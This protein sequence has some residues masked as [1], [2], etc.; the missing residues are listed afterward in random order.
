MPSTQF[1]T[2]TTTGAL[3]CT[4]LNSG[5]V[6]DNW[7]IV[8]IGAGTFTSVTA[9]FQTTENGT[10]YVNVA[11]IRLDTWGV[12]Q[13]PT[14]TN[15]T[16]RHWRV[17][18]GGA[19]GFRVNVTAVTST[20]GMT[21]NVNTIYD[22]AFTVQLANALS[23]SQT[24]SGAFTSSGGAVSLN[25]SS[26]F[27]TAINTGT[28]TGTVGIGN[29]S[30]GALTVASGAASTLQVTG[31]GLTVGT[32]TSGTTAVVS[33]G[34]LTLTGVGAS[35]WTPGAGA[36]IVSDASTGIKIA[37]AT[38]QKLGFFNATAVVQPAANTDT[39][40]GAAGGTTSVYLNTTFN[41]AGTA[42]YTIGGVVA[43]LKALGLLAA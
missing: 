9:T 35:V 16:A 17:P 28:S 5:A 7:A 20:A 23:G 41:G 34:L 27:N 15:S 43:S 11:S 26:N 30:A 24:L 39:T 3:T 13:T 1:S 33:A 25:A 19:Q 29:T 21:V 6:Q 22:A 42:A 12:E 10:D 8:E 18:I 4:N 31:A 40:T 38:T 14:V 36:T 32:L 2:F 37:T